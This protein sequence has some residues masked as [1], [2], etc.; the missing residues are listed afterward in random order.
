MSD[1]VVVSALVAA[2]VI[3]GGLSLLAWRRL[4]RRPDVDERDETR[5]LDSDDPDVDPATDMKG[6]S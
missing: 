1:A 2:A 5:Q 3:G 6:G 4:A